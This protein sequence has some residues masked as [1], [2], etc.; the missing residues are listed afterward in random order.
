MPEPALQA[1]QLPVPPLK[2]LP[3]P[4]PGMHAPL[5]PT[6]T[7]MLPS[8]AL[9]NCSFDG[10]SFEAIPYSSETDVVLPAAGGL[11]GSS[12]GGSPLR[13]VSPDKFTVRRSS[14][15]GVGAPP[16]PQPPHFSSA[17]VQQQG[18]TGAAHEARR[19]GSSAAT[20]PG[21]G[22]Q[23]QPAR[24]R[25]LREPKR[26]PNGQ[27]SAFTQKLEA[28]LGMTLP[29]RA[30]G[31]GV[32]AQPQLQHQ[33]QEQEVQEAGV[34]QDLPG[35]GPAPEAAAAPHAGAG[36]GRVGEALPRPPSPGSQLK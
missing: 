1:A 35:G 16:T 14:S 34:T 28:A 27:K 7:C 4:A 2:R 21:A 32:G 20:A 12:N 18:P 25:V 33:Q 13:T 22:T 8:R 5:P 9:C 10:S 11:G 24:R 6:L 31:D 3:L 17:P 29:R 30:V 23:G 36:E 19:D 26:P 15:S